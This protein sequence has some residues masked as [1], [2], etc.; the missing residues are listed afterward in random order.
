MNTKTLTVGQEVYI[1]NGPYG[2]KGKVVK[3]TPSGVDVLSDGILGA[4]L[5]RFDNEGNG[6]DGRHT[7]ECGPWHLESMS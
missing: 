4:G 6:C 5:F 2:Y 3:V 7:Y 1:I